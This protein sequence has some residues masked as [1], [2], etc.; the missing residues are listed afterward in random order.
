VTGSG[1]FLD[2]IHLPNMLHAA[3]L[4]SPH[5]HAK[6]TRID[7]AGALA[8]PNVVGV[9]LARDFEGNV[10]DIPTVPTNDETKGTVRKVLASDVVRHVGEPVAMILAEDRYSAGMQPSLSR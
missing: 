5:A 4:R 7:P 10:T 2:D 1:K 6:I 8:H 9:L 3:F